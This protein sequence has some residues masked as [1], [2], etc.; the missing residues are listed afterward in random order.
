MDAGGLESREPVL[1]PR[2][3]GRSGKLDAP[4][5]EMPAT[6]RRRGP[7]AMRWGARV[8]SAQGREADAAVSASYLA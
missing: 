4:F 3:R 7:A 1:D 6:E 2:R 8:W 5:G